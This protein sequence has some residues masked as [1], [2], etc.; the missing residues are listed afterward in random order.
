MVDI[1]KEVKGKISEGQSHWSRRTRISKMGRG[2][3]IEM[4]W[5]SLRL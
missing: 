3:G 1:R 4:I 2:L 5:Q